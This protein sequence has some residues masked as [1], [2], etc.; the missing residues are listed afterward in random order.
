[1]EECDFVDA[2]DLQ[3]WKGGV[4]CMTCQ[5]FAYGVDQHCH[6]VLR[7]AGLLKLVNRLVNK[8]PALLTG[9]MRS[10]R[11]ISRL[12]DRVKLVHSLS[13]QMGQPLR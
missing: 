7:L 5:H 9:W 2:R 6:A 1:M 10:D 4:V 3:G 12:E 11:S 13:S 8:N